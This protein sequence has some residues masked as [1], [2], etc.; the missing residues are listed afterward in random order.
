[1]AA[2][3]VLG[4]SRYPD[5]FEYHYKRHDIRALQ[6][7]EISKF[8]HLTEAGKVDHVVATVERRQEPK[9]DV[10]ITLKV[11]KPLNAAGA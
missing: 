7:I 3:T 9:A 8:V 4:V 5:Y 6:G 10:S 1:M 2:K 11:S